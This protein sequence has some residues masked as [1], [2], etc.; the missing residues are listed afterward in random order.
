MGRDIWYQLGNSRQ[1]VIPCPQRMTHLHIWEIGVAALTAW[2]GGR[3]E[4]QGRE[5]PVRGPE[6]EILYPNE[7]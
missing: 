2:Q 6:N 5:H 4:A 3:L 1:L 7:I